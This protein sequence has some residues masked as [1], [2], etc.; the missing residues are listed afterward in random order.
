MSYDP[1]SQPKFPSVHLPIAFIALTLAVYIGAQINSVSEQTK[2]LRWQISNADTN[3]QKLKDADKQWKEMVA[4]QNDGVKQSNAIQSEYQEL[5]QEVLDLSKVDD[6]AKKIVDKWGIQ[7]PGAGAPAAAS[8]Q[9]AETPP[10][11]DAKP[12]D[13]PAEKPAEKPA[14][15]PA[16]KK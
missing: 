3:E 14:D 15:K 13:K 6:D 12:A 4:K 2:L 7:R 11:A 10:A 16:D 9:K 5:F 1:S 8:D